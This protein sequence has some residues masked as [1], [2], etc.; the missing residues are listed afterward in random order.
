LCPALLSGLVWGTGDH[1]HTTKQGRALSSEFGP[2][3]SSKPSRKRLDVV[4]SQTTSDIWAS[5][6]NTSRRASAMGFATL[7]ITLFATDREAPINGRR[8]GDIDHPVLFYGWLLTRRDVCGGLPSLAGRER[9][10]SRK[11]TNESPIGRLVSLSGLS[12]K[13]DDVRYKVPARGRR[14][15]VQRRGNA[16]TDAMTPRQIFMPTLD[17]ALWDCTRTCMACPLPYLKIEQGQGLHKMC[18]DARLS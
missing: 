11:R 1:G 7:T 12:F 2:S 5:L 14:F 3:H 16:A 4:A 18:A 6:Q 17:G 8:Y 9:W 13:A 10:F 15:K